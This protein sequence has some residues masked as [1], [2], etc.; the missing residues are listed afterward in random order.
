LRGGVNERCFDS[1]EWDK[2]KNF[3]IKV[4][5]VIGVVAV[6]LNGPITAKDAIDFLR[7]RSADSQEDYG[8]D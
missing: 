1:P 7:T 5:I 2:V 6:L 8:P 4:G 3:S